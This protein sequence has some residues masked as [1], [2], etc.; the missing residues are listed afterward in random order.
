M[1]ILILIKAVDIQLLQHSLS[2]ISIFD[3]YEQLIDYQTIK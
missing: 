2:Q 3:Y 1:F